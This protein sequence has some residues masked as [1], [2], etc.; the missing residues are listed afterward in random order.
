[1]YYLIGLHNS[2]ETIPSNCR[3]RHKTHMLVVEQV[4]VTNQ[5]IVLSG[6]YKK[7]VAGNR[8]GGLQ[9]IYFSYIIVLCFPY[10]IDVLFN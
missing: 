10:L 6:I 7:I 4:F 9:D 5:V 1:M 3:K 2:H 8:G